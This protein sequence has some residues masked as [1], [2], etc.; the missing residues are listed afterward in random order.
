MKIAPPEGMLK[1]SSPAAAGAV[2]T[3]APSERTLSDAMKTR[4]QGP[5]TPPANIVAA[6]HSPTKKTPGTK[7]KTPAPLRR[8]LSARTAEALEAGTL[9][10]P[11]DYEEDDDARP[12]D[13]DAPPPHDDDDEEEDASEEEGSDDESDSEASSDEEDSDSDESDKSDGDDPEEPPAPSH[14][15]YDHMNEATALYFAQSLA[16]EALNAEC[17]ELDAQGK[18]YANEEE[19]REHERRNWKAWARHR[20]KEAAIDKAKELGSTPEAV[21]MGW[22]VRKSNDKHANAF[23]SLFGGHMVGG[24]M[25]QPLPKV[26]PARGAAMMALPNA[27]KHD[28]LKKPS[29][30]KGKGGKLQVHD[31]NAQG[32]VKN[33]RELAT[34]G[35]GL[36][37]APLDQS[38]LVREARKLGGLGA[39]NAGN[40]WFNMPAVE[41]TPELRRDMRLLKLRGA[42]DPKRFYKTDDTSKLP[43]HFQVG[44]VV[45]GAQDFF[46]ARM[47]KKERKRTFAEEIASSA[48]ITHARKKRFKKVQ[49]AHAN[50]LG[51]KHKRQLGGRQR[52][53][54]ETPSSTRRKK[55]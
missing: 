8:L 18:L 34:E 36:F 32:G 21:M 52:W 27:K 47:T 11:E 6:A 23:N 16:V 48:E 31:P 50:T 37:V 12:V 29:E 39:G 2:G 35:A 25:N 51:R 26:N 44:T 7:A 42:Y 15:P 5:A 30:R 38:R 10:V 22:G 14:N 54:K 41:Y 40:G 20:V 17:I 9:D 43:K 13:D 4:G 19:R 28:R 49:D 1:K 53:K 33:L 3:R 46:S 55:H 45:E 24:D